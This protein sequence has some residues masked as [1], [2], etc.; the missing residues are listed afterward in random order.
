LSRRIR[1]F[2]ESVG[3]LDPILGGLEDDLTRIVMSDKSRFAELF[4]QLEDDVGRRTVQA[5][6][7]ERL[8]ADFALDRTSFRKDE[9]NRI[10]GAEPM[11]TAQDLQLFVA[12]AL[13]YLGGTLFPHPDGGFEITLSQ[14]LRERMAVP[15]HS[16]RGVFD[17]E[18]AL[19]RDDLDFFALGH[20]FVERLIDFVL[21]L[22]DC[23][24][25]TRVEQTRSGSTEIEV[26][27]ELQASTQP[28]RAELVRHVIGPDLEVRDGSIT[29]LP[30]VSRGADVAVPS[31]ATEAIEA[32]EVHH[33]HELQVLRE[34]SLAEHD[35]SK[36]AAAERA[37]R[38]FEYRRVRLS[39]R[40]RDESDWIEAAKASADPKKAKILPAREGK[41]RKQM[42][43]LRELQ[44]AHEH[45]L[46]LIENR[47]IA[48][49][50]K[51]WSITVLTPT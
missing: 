2:E 36:R 7:N 27:Y 24:T 34:S 13:E 1:V 12:D 22:R 20:P 14:R 15:Q 39:K 21:D 16:W 48:V 49:S 6:E 29:S 51:V 44:D 33:R 40:I 11:A 41:L 17:P 19:I 28:P 8:L 43:S 23:F 42:D 37:V 4:E 47:Q 5:R 38:I 45:E 9:A 46:A 18:E 3:S 25:S 30:A 50:S 35:E 31:W 32:S 10:L 26:V